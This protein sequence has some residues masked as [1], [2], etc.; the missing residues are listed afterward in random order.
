[1]AKFLNSSFVATWQL[2]WAFFL[3]KMSIPSVTRHVYRYR[4]MQFP[5]LL[6][7]LFLVANIQLASA[8][9]YYP[10]GSISTGDTPC[11]ST[12]NSTCCGSGYACLSNRIC[13]AT[14]DEAQKPDAS[15]YVRGSCTDPTWKSASCPLFCISSHDLLS[16]GMGIAKCPNTPWT[17]TSV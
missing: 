2:F 1:V 12:G 3:C 5:F 16:G 10:D 15:L 8:Q 13:M 11:T 4:M 17:S 6:L 9:C 7:I 14:G